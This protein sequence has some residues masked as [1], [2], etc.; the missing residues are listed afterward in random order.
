M[1]AT[2]GVDVLDLSVSTRRVW[3]LLERLPPQARRGGE[4][5]SIESELLAG[6]IDQVAYLAWITLKA[7]GAKN[8][9]RPKPIQRPA[10]RRQAAAPK[11]GG[12]E[13]ERKSTWADA[14]RS[15]SAMPGVKVTNE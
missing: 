9:S 6:L 5:W 12:A 4:Q 1:L 3:V 7:N 2:Y 15:L 14:A 10:P 11:R 8:V 13:L